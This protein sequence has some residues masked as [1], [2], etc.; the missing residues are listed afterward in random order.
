MVDMG[1]N[2]EI[3]NMRCV[4]LLNH[5][6]RQTVGSVGRPGK[7]ALLPGE[8]VV[9]A[10]KRCVRLSSG[11]RY[12]PSITTI[13]PRTYGFSA[14]RKENLA[15]RQSR[16]AR[17]A[18]GKPRDFLTAPPIF[19][20]KFAISNSP[21]APAPAGSQCPISNFQFSMFNSPAPFPISPAHPPG[22]LFSS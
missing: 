18:D 9:G 15:G 3:S 21:A 22:I 12:P 4:H 20:F 2:A 14:R 6:T 1:D 5:D 10:A 13:W 11:G 19:K 16:R 7:E 17:C 8:F